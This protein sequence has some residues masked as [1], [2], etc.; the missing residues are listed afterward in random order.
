MRSCNTLTPS[1]GNWWNSTLWSA[2]CFQEVFWG[3]F[4]LF[5]FWSK[6]FSLYTQSFCTQII[7]KRVIVCRLNVALF[8]SLPIFSHHFNCLFSTLSPHIIYTH[9]LDCS[10]KAKKQYKYYFPIAFFC[11]F[12]SLLA[13]DQY[14]NITNHAIAVLIYFLPS[15]LLPT[16]WF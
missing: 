16:L 3:F 14:N 9:T 15:L 8:S 5:C 13:I 6:Q 4:V 12:Y 11:G 7:C 2:F 1:F 10:Q